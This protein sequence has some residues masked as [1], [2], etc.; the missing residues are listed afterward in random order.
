MYAEEYLENNKDSYLKM[1]ISFQELTSIGC[2]PVL[3]AH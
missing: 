2:T 1:L 3:Q